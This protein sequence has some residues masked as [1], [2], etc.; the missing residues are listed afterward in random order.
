M[1]EVVA[2]G[3]LGP[4]GIVT[5][6]DAGGI[7]NHVTTVV[8]PHW[9]DWGGIVAMV[10]VSLLCLPLARASQQCCIVS[11][12]PFNKLF[13]SSVK[14]DHFLLLTCKSHDWLPPIHNAYKS[15]DWLPQLIMSS[16]SS[17][18]MLSLV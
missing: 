16:S 10:H 3:T 2:V 12:Y 4:G 17:L 8:C 6:S 9:A 15:H 13:Y 11:Y 14:Q 18:N 1:V 5:S 7:A